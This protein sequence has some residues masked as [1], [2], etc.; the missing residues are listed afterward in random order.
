MKRQFSILNL[1]IS[2]VLYLSTCSFAQQ[3]GLLWEI[4]GNGLTQKSYLFGTMHV[5]DERVFNFPNGFKSA[6][7]ACQAFAMELN[8]DSAQNPTQALALM[9]YMM[10]KDGRTLKDLV[11]KKDYQ[12]VES[13]FNKHSPNVPFAMMSMMKPIFLMS[14]VE[15]A[16]PKPLGARDQPLDKYLASLAKDAQKPIIGLETLQEQMQALD[17]ISVEEQAKQLV[18][19]IKGAEKMKKNDKTMDELMK[20]YLAGDLTKLYQLSQKKDV[21][22]EAQQALI[23]KRNLNMVDRIDARIKSTSVFIAVG[24]LHLPGE[25]GILRLLERKGYTLK[26]IP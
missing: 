1:V 9:Q 4:S 6:F 8:L 11:S 12:K 13:F 15:Q 26:S 23:I 22:P 17:V 19:A 20:Y 25:Q 10:M 2:L 7:D 21:K 5:T 3:K 14:I 16:K 24:A 18:K